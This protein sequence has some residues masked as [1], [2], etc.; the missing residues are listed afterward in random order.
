MSRPKKPASPNVIVIP[1]RAGS[2]PKG[3]IAPILVMLVA[4]V[5]LTVRAMNPD[6]QGLMQEARGR[7]SSMLAARPA[8]TKKPIAKESTPKPKPKPDLAVA[9]KPAE[10]AKTKAPEMWDD[11]RKDAEKAKADRAEA[12]RIKAQAEK[13]LAN[14]PIPPPHRRNLRPNP[15]DIAAIL[16]QH[17]EM[18]RQMEAHMDRQ[19]KLFEQMIRAQR[20]QQERIMRE[21]GLP[22]PQWFGGATP[23]PPAPG[24]FAPLPGMDRMN[25]PLPGQPS[26]KDESGEDVRNGVKRTRRTRTIILG[27]NGFGRR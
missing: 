25:Q 4:V 14:A 24:L 15:A 17:H 12:E 3:M 19:Q 27:S 26:I 13:D 11:I 8:V 7:V 22:D 23:W 18:V 6:W 9:A 10:P 16:R 2:L 1:H 20:G 21:F 5:G